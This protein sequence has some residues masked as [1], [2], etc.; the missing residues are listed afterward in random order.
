VRLNVIA[1]IDGATAVAGVSGGLD[2]SADQA[3]FAVLRLQADIVLVAAGTVRA[4]NYGRMEVPVAVISRSSR[5]D[6]DSSFFSAA[7]AQPIVATVSE[8]PVVE[9][10]KAAD[11]ADV[12]I[13]GER[14][15]DLEAALGGLAERGSPGRSPRAA[16][17]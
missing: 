13:A 1:S 6:W 2:G 3:L 12:I 15:V 11:P 8:A 10:K 17:A 7:T 5:L 16:R 14:D 9:R 4:E